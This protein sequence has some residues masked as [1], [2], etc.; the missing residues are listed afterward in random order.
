MCRHAVCLPAYLFGFSSVAATKVS[1]LFADAHAPRH[2][3]SLHILLTNASVTRLLTAELLHDNSNK[4][5]S[6]TNNNPLCPRTFRYVLEPILYVLVPCSTH[7]VHQ[8]LSLTYAAHLTSSYA[9]FEVNHFNIAVRLPCTGVTFAAELIMSWSVA[10][11]ATRNLRKR[12][13]LKRRKIAHFYIWHSTFI[14]DTISTLVFIIQVLLLLLLLLLLLIFKALCMPII[15]WLIAC[16][17]CAYVAQHS[18][19]NLQKLHSL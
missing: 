19:P 13:V 3:K 4:L 6:Q 12:I 16:T 17:Y 2:M 9:V 7:L 14:F 15:L 1:L 11:V 8:A 10:F 5:I 18:C